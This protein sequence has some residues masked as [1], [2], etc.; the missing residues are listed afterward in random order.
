MK[1]RFLTPTLILSGDPNTARIEQTVFHESSHNSHAR[2]AGATFWANLF[3]SEINN[4]I[5]HGDP[6]HNGT[7]PTLNA[8]KRIAVAEG[9]ATFMEFYMM[10]DTYGKAWSGGIWQND[11]VT[12]M[13]NFDVYDVPM[14]IEIEDNRSW[15]L[16]G[17]FWDIKDSNND[18]IAVHRNGGGVFQNNIIDDYS[19]GTGSNLQSIFSKLTGSLNSAAALK[20]SLMGTGSGSASTAVKINQLF[21]SYGY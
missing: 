15:F 17:I 10:N 1:N 6:Y 11:P 12:F 4:D 18:N 19:I 7:K 9:W 8:A 3:A 5:Q 20:N 16:T 13:E 14:Q 2:K 21:M